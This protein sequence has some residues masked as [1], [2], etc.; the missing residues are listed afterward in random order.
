MKRLTAKKF[1]EWVNA[2]FIRVE[3]TNYV[4]TEVVRTHFT[5]DQYE[6]GACR[7]YVRFQSVSDSNHKGSFMCF[8]TLGEYSEH[9]N[10]GFEMVLEFVG[11]DRFGAIQSLQNITV[12][13]KRI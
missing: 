2:E 6:S 11:N 3:I 8:Y 10:A 13:L 9:I 1:I 4:A 5:T 7:F 12:N